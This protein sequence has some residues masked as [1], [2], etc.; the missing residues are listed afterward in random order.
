M[1]G[2]G[3]IGDVESQ[4][5][6]EKL[7]DGPVCKCEVVRLRMWPGRSWRSVMMAGDAGRTLQYASSV[8]WIKWCRVEL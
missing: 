3:H 2:T 5:G 6:G 8:D 4:G 7:T 1:E